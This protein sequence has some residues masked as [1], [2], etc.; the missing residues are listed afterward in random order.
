[1][2]DQVSKASIGE[3]LSLMLR[4]GTGLISKDVQQS[5]CL[6]VDLELLPFK[7]RQLGAVFLHDALTDLAL[8]WGID[9]F[10]EVFCEHV[11]KK[12][13]A[14]PALTTKNVP[15]LRQRLDARGIKD[16]L[17]MA[18][19]NP[20]GFYV[21]P[22]LE[23]CSAAVRQPGLRFVAMNTLASGTVKP[24][25]AFRF[26]GQFPNVESIVVGMSRKE[27]AEETVAAA[28]RHLKCAQR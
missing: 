24:D 25:D 15:L 4:G 2:L 17:V 3:K 5:L 21:N 13:S 27:H 7:G 12:H 1:M 16:V 26:L 19:F 22:S 23:E 14:Q 6:L 11:R 8:G 10:L 18:S 28:R 9:A 20:T